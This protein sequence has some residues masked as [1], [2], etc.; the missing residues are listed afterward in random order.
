M[1][2]NSRIASLIIASVIAFVSFAVI[3][4]CSSPNVA[5]QIATCNTGYSSTGGMTTYPVII[6]GTTLLD[7]WYSASDTQYYRVLPT[8]WVAIITNHGNTSMIVASIT[9]DGNWTDYLNA[10][11]DVAPGE[12]WAVS[13]LWRNDPDHGQLVWMS[14]ET[15][16][17]S[18]CAAT[19]AIS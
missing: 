15:I 12:S 10:P 19:F 13:D 18:T 9:V 7:G 6:P 8:A 1:P 5:E 14:S 4:G 16:A 11:I 3:H 17:K 2:V